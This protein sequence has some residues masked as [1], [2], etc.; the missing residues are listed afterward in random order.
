MFFWSFSLHYLAVHTSLVPRTL[1][2]LLCKGLR[3]KKEPVIVHVNTK[4]PKKPDTFSQRRL[5]NWYVVFPEFL[6]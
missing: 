3:E 5:Q 1:E 6:L 2:G 4:L